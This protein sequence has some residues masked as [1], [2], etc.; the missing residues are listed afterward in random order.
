MF[1]AEVSRNLKEQAHHFDALW[2]R[3]GWTM[4]EYIPKD[5]RHEL[6]GSVAGLRILDIGSGVGE[7]AV[8]LAQIGAHVVAT[9]VSTESMRQ[10]RAGA[11]RFGVSDRVE[12]AV[13]D[14]HRLPFADHTF[15]VVHGQ[16]IL[17]HLDL[18]RAG[19]ELVRVLRPGGIGVFLENS[20]KNP[21]LMLAR[22]ELVGRFGIARWSVDGEY[23]LRRADVELL[24]KQF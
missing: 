8:H 11:L 4:P 3:D 24:K 12:T 10:V 15:D 17:H 7:W 5:R 23:P 1:E 14:A 18:A 9:D 22:R 20:A 19:P 6:L 21:L 2:K 13:V 16:F